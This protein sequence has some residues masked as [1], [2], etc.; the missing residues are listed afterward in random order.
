M[1]RGM[2]GGGGTGTGT[3]CSLPRARKFPAKGGGIF[4]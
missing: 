2:I 3:G 4:V 1:L